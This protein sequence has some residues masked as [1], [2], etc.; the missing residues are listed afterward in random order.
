MLELEP[1]TKYRKEAYSKYLKDKDKNKLRKSQ[2][3]EFDGGMA[4]G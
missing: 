2:T 3:V 1:V 4:I